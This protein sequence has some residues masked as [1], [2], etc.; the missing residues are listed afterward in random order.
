MNIPD[1]LT[2]EQMAELEKQ[3]LASSVQKNEPGFI[4][5]TAR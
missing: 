3:G 4:Q 5:S 2:D 1:T